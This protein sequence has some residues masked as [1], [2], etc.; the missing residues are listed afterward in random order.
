MS[1]LRGACG[2]N[3]IDGKSNENVYKRS[4]ISCRRWSELWNDK[5]GDV[6]PPEMV[7]VTWREW[8]RIQ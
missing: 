2:V 4:G 5:E 3:K 7:W 6:Q 8:V 1:Y